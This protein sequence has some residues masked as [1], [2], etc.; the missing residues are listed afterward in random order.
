MIFND[1]SIQIILNGVKFAGEEAKKLRNLGLKIETKPDNSKVTNADIALDSLLTNLIRN[2]LKNNDLILSE[3]S[4]AN[5]N[6]PN[7][8]KQSFWS[9]DPIDS[10]KSFI[11]NNPYWCI[12]L[13]YIVDNKPIFGLIYAPETG[14]LWYGIIGVGAFKIENEKTTPIFSRIIPEDSPVLISSNE[15]VVPMDI[16]EKLKIRS[17][18]KIPSAIKFC[19]IAE[20][21][22]DY[23][24]RKRNKACDWDISAGH[25]LILSAGGDLGFLAPDE[26]FQYGLPQYNAPTLL[27]CGKIN[28]N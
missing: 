25:A 1:K 27:A 22:A 6:Y 13:A 9:I 4:V 14:V 23:Y 12:N 24:Y 16:I 20:G 11:E 3:E 7:G 28:H 15:Q 26:D 10:T 21:V 5:L 19:Y 17:E 2:E 8:I 18:I